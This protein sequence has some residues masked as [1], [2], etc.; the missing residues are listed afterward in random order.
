MHTPSQAS[1]LA[2]HD[3]IRHLKPRTRLGY[4]NKLKQFLKKANPDL[5]AL[6]IFPKLPVELPKHIPTEM[7]TRDILQKP[8]LSTFL[9]VRDRAILEL[10][11]GSGLRRS[12]VVNL[13]L[14]DIDF[15]SRVLRVNQS[16]GNKD[17]LVPFSKEAELWMKRY[18]DRVR[19]CFNPK[20][21][22]VFVTRTGKK[23]GPE[24]IE[25]TVKQY[26]PFSPHTYRHAY[27]THLLRGGMKETSLQKLLG[28]SLIATT[29]LYTQVTIEDLKT[30]LAK[31]HPRNRWKTEP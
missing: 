31:Y 13:T 21:S 8:D 23:P 10:L 1:V 17:R 14:D 25:R 16:K 30:N 26:A 20:E 19:P 2:F 12:E 7:Q 24:L 28:H 3:K 15:A 22:T 29:Q 9:G 27:A 4:L 18:I 11:Y 5:V 6:L